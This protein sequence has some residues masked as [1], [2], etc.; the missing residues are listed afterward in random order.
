MCLPNI[1]KKGLV[2]FGH[3]VCSP[4]IIR[5]L[6][7]CGMCLELCPMTQYSASRTTIQVTESRQ[8]NSVL[9]LLMYSSIYGSL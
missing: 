5:V 3:Y 2:C 7:Q 1:K 8:N 6:V 9:T 4:A